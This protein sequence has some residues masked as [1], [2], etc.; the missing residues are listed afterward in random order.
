MPRRSSTFVRLVSLAALA[1]SIATA[2]RAE[3]R[4]AVTFDTSFEDASLGQIEV[5]GENTFRL[6]VAGQEDERGHNRQANWYYFRMDHV[7][8]RDLTIVLTGWVG[9]YN[10]KPGAVAMGPGMQPFYSEDGEHWQSLAAM[11]WDR[12]KH[13][14]TV[15]LRPTADTI[16]LAHQPPYPHSRLL[17]LLEEIDRSPHARV[18]VVGRTALG[19]DL[20]VVTVT[21][22][23]RPDDGKKIVWLITRQH[24]WETGTS[25]AAEGALRFITSEDPRAKELRDHTV[26][27]FSPM[28][29]PDGCATG[30]VRFNAHGYDLNRY[31]ERVDLRD[32]QWLKRMPEVWYMKKAILAQQARHPIDLLVNFHND[33]SNEYMETRVEAGPTLAM[34]Q[35]LFRKLAADTTFD[36]TRGDVTITPHPARPTTNVLWTEDHVPVISLEEGITSVK[37]LRRRATAG[38]RVEFGAQLIAAMGEAVQ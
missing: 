1:V 24:A 29:D 2:L 27:I 12:V 19:R 8:G 17:R 6:H 21:N 5:I 35:R 13:E 16:W 26:F 31:W 4:A 20:H 3:G 32:K 9:E 18:E 7:A 28:M 15:K 37:K 11:T 10:D 33:E 23:D 22:F 34:M 25:F 36:P 14:A 38:D 30:K